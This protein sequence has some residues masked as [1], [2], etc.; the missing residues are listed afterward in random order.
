MKR[1]IPK[2]SDWIPILKIDDEVKSTY[3]PK[4]HLRSRK[5]TRWDILTGFSAVAFALLFFGRF[6]L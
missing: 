4:A 1:S 5:L 6:L 2:D 3:I